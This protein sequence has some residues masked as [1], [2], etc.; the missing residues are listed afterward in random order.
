MIGQLQ[1]DFPDDGLYRLYAAR[2]DDYRRAPPAP[3]W[4]GVTILDSK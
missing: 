3:D 1:A 2:V 4:D